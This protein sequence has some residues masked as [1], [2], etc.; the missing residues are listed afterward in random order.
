MTRDR[1]TIKK[2]FEEQEDNYDKYLEEIDDDR[3]VLTVI[4]E[5]PVNWTV[6]GEEAHDVVHRIK[7]NRSTPQ[8]TIEDRVGYRIKFCEHCNVMYETE[9]AGYL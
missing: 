3:Q 8:Q 9:P 2:K 6:Y 1:M 4:S 5:W 7:A